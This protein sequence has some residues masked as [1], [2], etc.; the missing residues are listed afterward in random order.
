MIR[1][2]D[3]SRHSLTP[4]QKSEH[5]KVE[6]EMRSIDTERNKPPKTT[7]VFGGGHSDENLYGDAIS[8][9]QEAL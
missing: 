2:V 1:E 4:R 8:E 9:H 5:K 7:E 6:I 3:K